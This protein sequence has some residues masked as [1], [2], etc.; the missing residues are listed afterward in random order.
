MQILAQSHME[1]LAY[2]HMEFLACYQ[3]WCTYRML[4]IPI[5]R[6]LQMLVDFPR[7]HN[8]CHVPRLVPIS[9]V[10]TFLQM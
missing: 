3:H 5:V 6:P 9:E 8:C 1:I 2:A 4:Y 7:Y 10:D